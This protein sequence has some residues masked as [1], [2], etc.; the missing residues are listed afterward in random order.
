MATVDRPAD[1]DSP[2]TSRERELAARFVDDALPYLDQL[3]KYARRMTRNAVD[4]E[5][6]VQETMLRAYAGFNTFTEGTN[7]RAW[8]FRIM[9][10]SY[11][12]C[13]RRA[14]RRPSEYLTDYFTDQQLAALDRHS[15][16]AEVDAIAA[17]PD[18]EL[19]EAMATLP[20][21][22]RLAIYYR[23][24]VG[25]QCREIAEIMACREGTVVSRLNRGRRRLRILLQASHERA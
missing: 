3:Q 24:V 22:F 25:L 2:L 19:A 1:S 20:Q 7:L 8:L 21:Q 17:L 18:V 14:Q 5:D 9:T 16:S 12:N 4:A 15:R 6:L 10:N 11:I 23:D 13:A